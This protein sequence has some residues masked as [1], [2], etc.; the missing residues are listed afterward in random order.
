[1]VGR[2]LKSL[3]EFIQLM[4]LAHEEERFLTARHY[5]CNRCKSRIKKGTDQCWCCK[6]NI[7]WPWSAD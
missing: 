5:L 3:W 6:A 1:M 4:A 7:I 2:W